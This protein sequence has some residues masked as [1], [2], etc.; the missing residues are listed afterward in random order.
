[1]FGVFLGNNEGFSFGNRYRVAGRVR[2]RQDTGVGPRRVET[3]KQIRP[4]QRLRRSALGERRPDDDAV[5]RTALHGSRRQ[6]VDR[7]R[8]VRGG[9]R[10]HPALA[11]VSDGRAV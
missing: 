4:L 10:V 7:T 2:R 1:M 8:G 11:V 5:E 3:A 6:S 9:W